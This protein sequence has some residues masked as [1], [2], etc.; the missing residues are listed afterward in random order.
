MEQYEQELTL[1]TPYSITSAD[2][3]MSSRLKLG[4]LVNLLIQ[5]AI[6]S[7]DSLGFGFSNLSEQKLFWV[8]RNLTVEIYRPMMWSELAE[9]ETWPK[10]LEGVLY[11]RDFVVR[12]RQGEVVARATSG[13]L[14]L[15]LETKRPKRFSVEEMDAFTRLR[16]KHALSYSPE[17]LG[18][19]NGEVSIVASEKPRFTDIDLNRHVTSTRY[20]DWMVDTL[21]IDFLLKN[22][23]SKL[24][25]NYLK[26]TMPDHAVAISRYEQAEGDFIFEG[27][28]T[29]LSTPSFRGRVE[30]KCI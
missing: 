27:T 3:D 16:D 13:W 19:L 28:N 25:I 7:A 12:D 10:N 17:K 5:S 22:Y 20:I 2:T 26:E 14:A 1:I 29:S 21:P 24:S 15:D 4:S 11:L 6:S 9:V 23:P 30:F 8:L 18:A